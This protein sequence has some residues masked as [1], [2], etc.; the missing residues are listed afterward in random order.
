LK[1]VK[2]VCGISPAGI[3]G[4]LE[5]KIPAESEE[6]SKKVGGKIARGRKPAQ[7]SI[8]EGILDFPSP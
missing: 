7:P 8:P 4:N 1:F 6:I 2:T 3:A 5:K